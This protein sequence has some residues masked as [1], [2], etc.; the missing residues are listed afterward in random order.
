MSAQVLFA[1]QAQYSANDL[2]V[3]FSS[4]VQGGFNNYAYSWNFGDG[5]VVSELANPSHT[6]TQAGS[7]TVTLTV[8][9][10]SPS[11]IEE[12]LP[13]IL[14][15]VT[16]QKQAASSGS[17]GGSLFWLLLVLLPVSFLR[18]KIR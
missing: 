15:T 6:Y 3:N 11:G 2:R 5:S 7:Y 1:A 10:T 16:V 13:P 14:L 12:I 9:N 18:R 17:S 4:D 8:S